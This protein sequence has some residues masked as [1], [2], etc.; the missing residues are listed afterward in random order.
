MSPREDLPDF[1]DV[2]DTLRLGAA[3]EAAPRFSPQRAPTRAELARKRRRALLV[4][5]AWALLQLAALGVRGDLARLPLGYALLTIA[6]P[7]LLGLAC[8]CTG[9]WPGAF[10]LGARRSVALGLLLAT[11]ATVLGGALLLPAPYAGGPSGDVGSLFL[12]GSIALGWAALPLVAAALTL[13]HSFAANATLRSALLGAAAG[14]GA[15]VA[16]QLRCPLT[17]GL[18]ITVAHGGVLLVATLLGA[19]WLRRVTRI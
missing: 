16:A 3:R 13:D 2:P 14:V 4:S 9:V 10:G 7:L 19:Y 6:L 11:P 5:G 15:A 8:L 18:H 12:C 1:S 17:G